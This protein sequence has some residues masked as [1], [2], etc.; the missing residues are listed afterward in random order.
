MSKSK[1]VIAEPKTATDGITKEF[2]QC[3]DQQPAPVGK[4]PAKNAAVN[5]SLTQPAKILFFAPRQIVRRGWT[6][7]RT[8]RR[9]LTR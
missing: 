4:I 8:N 3:Q 6:N 5:P 2:R 1:T 7:C 9:G